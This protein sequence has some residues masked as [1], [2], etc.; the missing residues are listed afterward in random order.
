M[1]NNH[2]PEIAVC[3]HC[4][5]RPVSVHR[6]RAGTYCSTSCSAAALWQLRREGKAANPV[7]PE[8][9]TR[10]P[11]PEGPLQRWNRR[12]ALCK[13]GVRFELPLEGPGKCRRRCDN[14]VRA[15]HGYVKV[16]G[17][18]V[19]FAEVTRD[20]M[21]DAVA[22][23]EAKYKG[24]LAFHAHARN[25]FKAAGRPKVCVVCGYSRHAEVAHIRGVMTFPGKATLL[26]INA[27]DNLVALCPNHHHELDH[28]LMD[29]ADLDKL[30]GPGRIG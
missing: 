14:C 18:F 8:G 23:P 17:A 11:R 9:M 7:R 28:G 27:L 24:S 2:P 3:A 29:A 13:C 21:L 4:G 25:I 30:K 10:G 22:S 26:E 1:E 6:N 15:R 12:T 16:Q 20:Q 19:P 5:V